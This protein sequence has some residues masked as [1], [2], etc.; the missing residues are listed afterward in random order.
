MIEIR[1]ATGDDFPAIWRMFHVI[2]EAGDTYVNDESFTEAQGRTMWL[3]PTIA[4]YV[5]LDEGKI[6]G[7]YKILPNMAG[8]GSHIA[9]GSYIVDAAC[10]G[11]G[12]GR[13][14]VVH[15]LGEAKRLGYRAIQF[16]CVVS[17]NT[18][19]VKLY[20]DLGFAIVATIPE[21]F[22]HRTLG[23]VDT[24]V[25]HRPLNDIP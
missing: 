8:R 15:S 6:V 16:N 22:N 9:N 14:M 23:Y 5:A 4:T 24:Y 12:L 3:G 13:Q 10:R 17:T 2:I 18:G 19:A 7:A 11:K 20:K 21:G 25:M 1:A